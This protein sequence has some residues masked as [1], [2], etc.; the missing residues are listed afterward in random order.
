MCLVC[1]EYTK[2]KMTPNEALQALGEIAPD[3]PDEHTEELVVR[4]M[5]DFWNHWN[6]NMPQTDQLTTY[7]ERRKP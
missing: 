3:P 6:E 4:L 7:M 5:E 2:G 1:I